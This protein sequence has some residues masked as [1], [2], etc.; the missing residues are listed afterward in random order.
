M[1]DMKIAFRAFLEKTTPVCEEL[2]KLYAT[3]D[4]I[5]QEV[6]KTTFRLENDWLALGERPL[7]RYRYRHEMQKYDRLLARAQAQRPSHDTALLTVRVSRE[8]VATQS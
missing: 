8:V 7:F 4:A 2:A 3:R 6:I 5:I 1:H